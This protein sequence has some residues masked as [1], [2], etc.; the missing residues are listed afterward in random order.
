M[1]KGFTI[2]VLLLAPVVALPPVTSGRQEKFDV[3]KLAEGVYAAVR[4]DPPGFAVESNSLF[5]IGDDGVIVV[6]SQSNL[7]AT[8]ET[9]AA[10]RKLTDKPV[11]YV[12]NTHWHDDHVVGNQ[13][14]AEAFPGVAFVAH[15]ATRAYLPTK[16]AA[17][18][19]SWHEGGL[20]QFVEQLRNI[21]KGGVNSKG[22]PLDEEQR[23]SLASDIALGEGYMTVPADF[24]PVLPTVTLEDKLTIYQ[25][26][27]EVDVLYLGRGH[28]SGDVVVYL[29]R[30][31]IVAAGDLVVWPVPFVGSDQS[32]VGDWGA[33]VEKLIALKPSI[34]VPGHGPVM[35]DDSYPRLVERLMDSIKQQVG[36]AVARGETLEQARKDVNLDEMRKAFAGDSKV[37]NTLF[38][39]YVV[40]PAV[41]SAFNDATA[42]R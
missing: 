19:K 2:L 42:K 22:E 23:A 17:A 36:A 34:I 40:G 21:L 37:R 24:R 41:E 5:V 3:V 28:T 11:R 31:G 1:K 18:R 14:Y 7:A 20:S 29:P 9:L 8:R 35:H 30:E 4:R 27:R 25:G 12:V 13:V 6:D 32:H 10:L 39:V 16:G 26:G 15:A 33:T 38:S